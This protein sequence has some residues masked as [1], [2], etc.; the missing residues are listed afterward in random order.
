MSNTTTEPLW[1]PGTVRIEER[2]IVPGSREIILHPQPTSDPNDPL[3]WPPWRKCLNLGLVIFWVAMVAEFINAP[4]PT[5]SPMQ[6]E[7]GYTDEILNDSY[8]AGCAALGLGSLLLIPFAL[9]F[10]R[11]PIYLLCTVV[12]FGVSIWSARMTTVGDLMGVNVIQCFFASLAE[13]IVQ[14][15]IRDLFFVHQ[16]GRMNA[17]Y[18]WVWLFATY[19]GPLVAGF[20]TGALGWR[21]VWWINVVVFGG[22]VIVVGFG[23]EETKYVPFQRRETVV[24]TLPLPSEYLTSKADAAEDKK[25]QDSSNAIPDVESISPPTALTKPTI[26]PSIPLK[27]Y[28]QR[29]SL[30]TTTPST[31]I[32]STSF[33]RTYLH[34]ISLPLT[35]LFTIPAITFTALVYG[36]LVGLGDIMSTTMSTFLP[37]APYNFTS[38][39][40]GLM[41]LPRMIGVSIG[42]AITGPL[43]DWWIVWLARRR[44]G[45]YEPET[46][47][48]CVLPF[49]MF[50]PVGALLFGVGLSGGLP[51]PV[52]AVGLGLYN[53]GVAP[54]NGIVITYL[55]DC[56][57]E[58]IGP[59]LVSVTLV[60]NAF[61]TAFIFALSPW[62]EAIGLKWVLVTILVIACVILAG[63]GVFIAWG[64][65]FRSFSKG[66]YLALVAGERGVER[67][68]GEVG[69]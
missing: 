5:W 9:E 50:I 62:E 28:W 60:R 48:W 54:V 19:L 4:T 8:A 49:L 20:V 57:E 44:G 45:V 32:S 3:N 53:V 10:G 23:Y 41:H 38:S 13:S 30:T 11:R 52:V 67:G 26:D 35:L 61:S 40:V 66:R 24:S 6:D 2:N 17:L 14:M 7:L 51:W 56:Y 69:R 59:S 46:R 15:T 31:S 68:R 43:S 47:L 58:I 16:R 64:R 33:S 21:W 36:I 42:A 63:V 34:T 12:Q 27:T 22:A 55:T 18:V 39:Q 1:P 37:S 29:L 25:P 65:R